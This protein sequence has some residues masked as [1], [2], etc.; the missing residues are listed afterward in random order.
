[1]SLVVIIVVIPSAR[2]AIAGDIGNV[3]YFFAE[4]RRRGEN[5]EEDEEQD[6]ER[7]F[8][9]DRRHEN[10]LSVISQDDKSRESRDDEHRET[11]PWPD[12]A[13][14]S[15]IRSLIKRRLSASIVSRI[16]ERTRGNFRDSDF[17]SLSLFLVLFASCFS[18]SFR[19]RGSRR[20]IRSSRTILAAISKTVPQT[21]YHLTDGNSNTSTKPPAVVRST[22]VRADGLVVSSLRMP[23]HKDAGSHDR[24]LDSPNGERD[25]TCARVRRLARIIRETR[26][27]EG[28]R[29]R[30][31]KGKRDRSSGELAA[32]RYTLAAAALHVRAYA[33]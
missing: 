1:M 23:G 8:T 11:W 24:T 28:E 31:R 9:L 5:E 10:K 25:V 27:R 29:D 33:G 12:Q 15:S 7:D 13:A 2:P 19:F 30:Q 20:Y 26:T 18:S 3:V 14:S 4:E 22:S 32:A 16:S 6:E 21:G 17:L